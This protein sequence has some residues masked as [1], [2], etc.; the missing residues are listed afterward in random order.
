MYQW[1]CILY[2]GACMYDASFFLAQYVT[3]SM[4]GLPKLLSPTLV[5]QLPHNTISKIFHV[6]IFNQICAWR[7]DIYRSSNVLLHTPVAIFSQFEQNYRR[8][9]TILMLIP[10]QDF[11]PQSL[12][13]WYMMHLRVF[14]RFWY[15]DS[16]SSPSFPRPV[17]PGEEVS[18]L[19]NWPHSLITD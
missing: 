12:R 8:I 3:S 15:S 1:S 17:M 19:S 7:F 2:P 18:I 16:W 4:S 13:P 6:N 11:E 9:I 10:M 14:W 5:R